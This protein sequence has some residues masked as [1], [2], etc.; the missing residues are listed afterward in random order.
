MDRDTHTQDSETGRRFSLFAF[1]AALPQ[2]LAAWLGASLFGRFFCGY[3]KAEE[4]LAESRT[5]RAVSH[6][7][8]RKKFSHYRY[9]IATLVSKSRVLVWLHRIFTVLQQTKLRAYGVFFIT[10]GG[11]ACL[12]YTAEYFVLPTIEPNISVLITGIV[13]GLMGLPL[14]FGSQTLHESLDEGK[15]L[16]AFLYRVAGLR[17]Y[18]GKHESK[19]QITPMTAFL[20]GSLF[21]VVSFFSH[22]LYLLVGLFAIAFFGLLLHSPEFSLLSAIFL[23]PFLRVHFRDDR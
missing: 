5:A 3:A 23:A 21:G 10:F 15:F 6:G 22:P 2:R 20:L 11:Y 8:L 14:L 16:G 19:W 1:L 12:F 9:R 13:A 18:A 7:R 4:L 17:I